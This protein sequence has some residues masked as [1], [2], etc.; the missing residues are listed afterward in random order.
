MRQLMAQ[1]GSHRGHH[2]SLPT[3]RSRFLDVAA[4]HQTRF[5]LAFPRAGDQAVRR[6]HYVI[7]TVRQGGFNGRPLELLGPIALALGLLLP[8]PGQGRFQGSQR[9]G[10]DGGKEGTDDT[11]LDPRWSS[12]LTR[13]TSARQS[14]GSGHRTRSAPQRCTPS[15]GDAHTG[16][17]SPGPAARRPP[18]LGPLAPGGYERG[19]PGP[20]PASARDG[21]GTA[22][23]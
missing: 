3:S 2:G 22:P 14:P 23:S 13:H 9:G 4:G 18:A 10:L 5:L 17:K 16:H 15:A 8:R 7:A 12:R 6:I 19:A 1:R 11:R 20:G 21:P